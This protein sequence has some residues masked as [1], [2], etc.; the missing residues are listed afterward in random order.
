MVHHVWILISSLPH[1]RMVLIQLVHRRV[2]LFLGPNLRQWKSHRMAERLSIECI[3]GHS[4]PC[5][6]RGLRLGSGLC[7]IFSTRL[8]RREL[9]KRSD[10]HRVGVLRRPCGITKLDTIE[11]QNGESCNFLA[12]KIE[13][14]YNA[15]IPVYG[16][17]PLVRSMLE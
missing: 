2:L 17:Y 4:C 8:P 1:Q 13:S 11:Q 7:R 9:G 12:D 16:S 14:A 10:G 6:L 3:P 5:G 15:H